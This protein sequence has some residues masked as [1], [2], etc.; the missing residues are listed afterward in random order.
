MTLA[1]SQFDGGGGGST[2]TYLYDYIELK[3]LSS[4]TQSL[5]GLSLYYGSSTG[6]F[7]STTANAFT[8]PN[9]TLGPG[10]YFLIQTGASGTAGAPL[11][12]A[13]D[14]ITSNI[15]LSFG[16]GKIALVTAGLPINACGSTA[17]PCDAAQLSFVVDWVA[18]GTGG[19]GSAGN[20]EG[21]T[22]VNNGTAMTTRQGGVRKLG[23]CQDTDNN[24]NDFDVVT[25]PFPRNSSSIVSCGPTPTASPTPTN[26]YTPTP[27]RTATATATSTSTLTSTST[28]TATATPAPPPTLGSYVSTNIALSGNTTVIPDATPTN[29][30][31]IYVSTSTDFKGHFDA[32]AG[33]GHIRITNAHPGSAFQP[34]GV[35]TVTVTAEGSGGSTS[36]TFPLAVNDGVQC[37]AVFAPAVNYTACCNMRSVA[38]GDFNADEKQDIVTIGSILGSNI[39]VRLGD[40][41]GNFGNVSAF[42]SSGTAAAVAV[43]D[44]NS[45][46]KQDL[47]IANSDSNN[48]SILIGTGTGSF[49]SPFNVNVGINP[50]G[51]AVADM[52]RDGWQ[53]IAVANHSSSYVS[54]LKN[55]G[56]GMFTAQPFAVGREQSSVVFGDFNGDGHPDIAAAPI[57]PNHIVSILLGDG[58]GSFGTATDFAVGTA[59]PESIAVGDFNGDGK[60]D[61]AVPGYTG[62]IVVVI[63]GNGLGGFGSATSFPAGPSPYGIVVGDFSGDGKQDIAVADYDSSPSAVGVL[64]GDGLGG[65]ASPVFFNVAFRPVALAVGDFNGNSKQDIVSANLISNNF[66]VLSGACSSISGTATYGNAIGGT[67]PRFVQNV[68]LSGTGSVAVSTIS[69]SSGIYF[70]QGFGAGLYTVTPSKMAGQ[71]GISSFDAARVAQHVAGVNVLTGNQFIVADVSRNGTLSSFDAGQIARYVAGVTGFGS[72]GNW[73]FSPVNRSYASVTSNIT[74]ED[75]SALLMGEVTGNWIP[76]AARPIGNK[77]LSEGSGPERAMTIELPKIG[78]AV[79]KEIKVPVS[80]Q[81]VA[82]KSVISYEFDLRY[83]P[84]VIWPLSEPV[85]VSGTVSRGLSV[86]SN[87]KEPGLLR[88]VVYGPMPIDADGV[89]L[90]LRFTPVGKPG[91]VSPLSWERIMFN[92]GEPRVNTTD[93]QVELFA[94]ASK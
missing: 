26:T 53:D 2:G 64:L 55:L 43:G 35:F 18:Y 61:I 51:I 79:R 87:H 15:N 41:L 24:N 85:D 9:L 66:S 1:I 25:D 52:N 4:N 70:L 80:I 91:S 62:D 20:G 84:S 47:A 13:P 58:T 16:G 7:A 63:L 42:G 23:G 37:P 82:H 72:T 71:N 17:A 69:N 90:N 6:N 5:N 78:A 22:S 83:N 48:V 89:L 33:T 81:G 27:T 77:R 92:E 73:I 68:L 49:G 54:V 32:D 29:T 8:L 28:A 31:R 14:A 39:S 88:V 75:Y 59:S 46:G 57:S 93:G 50:A 65:F 86:V 67:N 44:L 21:G 38:V 36:T 3:N 45:D 34:A 19:N 76:S 74:S 60:Q 11:P 12:L 94:A 40:G 56:N 30:L 10:Q